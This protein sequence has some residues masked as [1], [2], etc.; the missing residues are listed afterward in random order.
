MDKLKKSTPVREEKPHWRKKRI[1]SCTHAQELAMERLI[2]KA[3]QSGFTLSYSQLIR[4]A[5]SSLEKLPT[6]EFE[7][8]IMATDEPK[9][10]FEP[11]ER[12][13]KYE[14]TAEEQSKLIRSIVE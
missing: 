8:Q 1:F 11:K 13:P 10:G 4:V 3:E 12:N 7:A 6:S 5:L 14:L 9:F 2:K